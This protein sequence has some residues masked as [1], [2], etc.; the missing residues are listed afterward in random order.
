M[1]QDKASC[2][3]VQE[4]DTQGFFN[5][6]HFFLMCL[7]YDHC[8]SLLCTDFGDFYNMLLSIK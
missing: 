6:H 5:K 7:I 1:H 2:T 8:D 4:I 3:Q